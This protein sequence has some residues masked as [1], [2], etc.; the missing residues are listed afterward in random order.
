MFNLYLVQ[1]VDKYG[2][3][4]FLPLAVSYQWLDDIIAEFW[5]EYCARN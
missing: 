4:S 5:K 1:T 3:N 2:P